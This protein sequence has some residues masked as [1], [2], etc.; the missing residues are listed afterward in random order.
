MGFVRKVTHGFWVQL[1]RSG[2]TL[3]GVP[4]REVQRIG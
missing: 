1:K 3:A 4:W 2:A